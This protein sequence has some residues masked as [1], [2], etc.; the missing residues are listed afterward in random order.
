MKEGG[1]L[2]PA[3]LSRDGD[4]AAQDDLLRQAE[5]ARMAEA[6]D[7]A[8]GEMRGHEP[9]DATRNAAELRSMNHHRGG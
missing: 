5:G 8:K 4:D 1:G 9:D 7:G 2:P 6:G 3:E